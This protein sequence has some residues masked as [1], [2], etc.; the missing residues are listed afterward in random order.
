MGS[1]IEAL[2]RLFAGRVPDA[3]S[4]SRVLEIVSRPD[5]WS[6]AHAVFDEIRSRANRCANDLQRGQYW[7]EEVC[8]QSIYNATEPPDP[9]DSCSPFFVGGFALSLARTLRIDV[10]PVVDVLAPI[11]VVTSVPP[12]I[13]DLKSWSG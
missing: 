8:L 13:V 2:V 1:T 3:E 5:R 11:K 12:Q 9:F 6:A 7:F 10:T 4:N